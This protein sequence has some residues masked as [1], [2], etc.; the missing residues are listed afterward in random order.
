MIKGKSIEKKV[1]KDDFKRI[2]ARVDFSC[3]F[4]FNASFGK[5]KTH[6]YR[7]YKDHSERKFEKPKEKQITCYFPGP[8]ENT[9]P[10][11]AT[12]KNGR[13]LYV[14]DKYYDAFDL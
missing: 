4:F 1:S 14:E 3:D 12:G 10:I 13:I 8:I 11:A 7:F 9:F 6:Q 5:G 2:K